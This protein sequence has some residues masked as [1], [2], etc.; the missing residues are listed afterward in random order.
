MFELKFDNSQFLRALAAYVM[1]KYQLYVSTIISRGGFQCSGSVLTF[2]SKGL[3][4]HDRHD[5][6]YVQYGLR[7]SAVAGTDT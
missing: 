1:A 7:S 5:S 2:E 4:D 6:Q 3:V